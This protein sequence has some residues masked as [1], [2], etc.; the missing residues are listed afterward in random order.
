MSGVP[1]SSENLRLHGFFL[2]DEAPKIIKMITVLPMRGGINGGINE[3]GLTVERICIIKKPS[4][5]P[6]RFVSCLTF[7]ANVRP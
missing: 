3:D 4:F 5:R 1:Q 6:R 2:L 7:F